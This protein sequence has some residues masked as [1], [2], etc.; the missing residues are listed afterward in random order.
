MCSREDQSCLVKVIFVEKV[1]I[2]VVCCIKVLDIFCSS[3]E[4]K[5]YNCMYKFNDRGVKG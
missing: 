5:C 1:Q 3:C 4:Q 2:L